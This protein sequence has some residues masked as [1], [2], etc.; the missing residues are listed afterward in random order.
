MILAKVVRIFLVF[1]SFV[2]VKQRKMVA[3]ATHDE[4][5]ANA[6][7]TAQDGYKCIVVSVSLKVILT[8]S[9][10]LE[11]RLVFIVVIHRH[12]PL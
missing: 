3:Y 5:E 6:K 11:L 4:C 9:L 10:L 1:L 8:R 7:Y 2:L 12:G